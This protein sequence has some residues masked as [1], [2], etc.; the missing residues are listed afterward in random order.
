MCGSG[1]TKLVNIAFSLMEERPPDSRC[2]AG[3]VVF[4]GPEYVLRERG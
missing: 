2:S 3:V 1:K 4:F